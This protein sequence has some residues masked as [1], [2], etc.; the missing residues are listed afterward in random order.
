MSV[1]QAGNPQEHHYRT[2]VPQRIESAGRQRDNPVE[3]RR[4]DPF[5]Q[6]FSEIACPQGVIKIPPDADPVN[7]TRILAEAASP[8]N[9]SPGISQISVLIAA[10]AGNAAKTAPR[11][12]NAA[13]LNSVTSEA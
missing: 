4:I 7:P 8:G 3:C 2:I 9:A 13:V 5:S 11:P 6:G 12:T 1:G 10:K